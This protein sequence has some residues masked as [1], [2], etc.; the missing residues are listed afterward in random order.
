MNGGAVITNHETKLKIGHVFG[1]N[2]FPKFWILNPTYTF[3]LPKYQMVAGF[4]DIL[5]HI[6]EQYFSDFDDCTS[7]YIM[8]GLMKS[9]IHSSRIAVENPQDYEARSNIM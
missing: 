3:T 9:L 2:V 4:Y 1:E 6:T 8:E 5:N 7:D